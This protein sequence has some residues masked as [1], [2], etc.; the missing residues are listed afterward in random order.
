M[1]FSLNVVSEFAEIDKITVKDISCQHF[2]CKRPGCHHG[3]SKTHVRDR[4]FKRAR[5]YHLLCKR[6]GCYLS[7]SKT[8]VRD[9]IFK[10]IQFIPHKLNSVPGN[11]FSVHCLGPGGVRPGGVCIRGSV[12]K[13]GGKP[14]IG[15]GTQT[16]TQF[17]TNSILFQVI[18]S[19][20]IRRQINHFYCSNHIQFNQTRL[21]YLFS[22]KK[23]RKKR[24]EKKE[25]ES[26]K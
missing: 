25:K 9:W 1:S 7:A 20:F 10:L 3:V 18:H 22:S 15:R 4:I 11:S 13:G 24:K 6:P 17:L 26:Y 8:R 14:Q 19:L 2:L 5:T 21:N 12:S 16:T 23:K